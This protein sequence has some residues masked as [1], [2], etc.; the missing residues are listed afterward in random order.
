MRR[1]KYMVLRGCL[2]ELLYRKMSSSPGNLLHR[3]AP[4]ASTCLGNNTYGPAPDLVGGGVKGL[5]C[6][7]ILYG[8]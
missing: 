2:G 8:C 7:W 6:P 1:N 3:G 5:F 4:G